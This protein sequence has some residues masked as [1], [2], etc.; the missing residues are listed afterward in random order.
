MTCEIHQN[1]IGTRFYVTINHCTDTG[2]LNVLDANLRQF[3]FKK[4]SDTVVTKTASILNDG[5]AESGVVY[6]DFLAGDLDEAGVWKMQAKVSNVSG[7]YY[8]DIYNF[9]VHPNL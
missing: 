7:T 1:E 4:P 3:I 2:Y 5:S 8:T 6:Y 9:K